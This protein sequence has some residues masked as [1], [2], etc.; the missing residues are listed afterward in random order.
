MTYWTK[1]HLHWQPAPPPRPKTQNLEAIIYRWLLSTVVNFTNWCSNFLSVMVLRQNE[2]LINKKNLYY[3]K[4]ET[5][6]FKVLIFFHNSCYWY[7]YVPYKIRSKKINTSLIPR[8]KRETERDKKQTVELMLTT[9]LSSLLR[10]PLLH[11]P[12]PYSP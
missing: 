3:T 12:F 5:R 1:P 7:A 2:S 10:P 11:R 8:R 9:L 4:Q 6:H